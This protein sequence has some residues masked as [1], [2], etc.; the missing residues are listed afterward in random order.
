[1]EAYGI[2]AYLTH[3]QA[4][5]A[6]AESGNHCNNSD[7]RDDDSLHAATGEATGSELAKI[8]AALDKLPNDQRQ[9]VADHLQR[10]VTSPPPNEQRS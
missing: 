8:T 4:T 7:L 2:R 9:A 1:M 10:P 3:Q 5:K 6:Q